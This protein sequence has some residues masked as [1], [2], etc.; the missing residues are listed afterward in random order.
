MKNINI[1][2]WRGLAGEP[3]RTA[4]RLL[5]STTLKITHWQ[6]G[7]DPGQRNDRAARAAGPRTVALVENIL[8]LIAH[9]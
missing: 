8:A 3:G 2:D 9:L 6:P 7:G 5:K 1:L 4:S